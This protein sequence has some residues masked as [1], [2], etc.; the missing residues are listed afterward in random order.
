LEEEDAKL[1]LAGQQ[2]GH[3]SEIGGKSASRNF[4]FEF[5]ITRRITADRSGD[6]IDSKVAEKVGFEPAKTQR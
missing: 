5:P 2:I 3:G 6:I 4:C 1:K